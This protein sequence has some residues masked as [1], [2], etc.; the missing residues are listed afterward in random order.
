MFRE[1]S[2]N[3]QSRDGPLSSAA[4]SEADARSDVQRSD[5]QTGARSD[6]QTGARSDVQ[7]VNLHSRRV[8]QNLSTQDAESMETVMHSWVRWLPAHDVCN[9]RAQPQPRAH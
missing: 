7:P 8:A 1:S 9:A 4:M 2:M 6:V 3:Q 5:V